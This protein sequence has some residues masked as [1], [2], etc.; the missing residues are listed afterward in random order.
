MRAVQPV[1]YERPA[2][3][4][5]GLGDLVLVMREDVIHAATMD[6]E[7]LAEVFEAHGRTFDMPARAAL[8]QFRL[9][10]HGAIVFVP[11]LPQREIARV[12]R[13]I[14]VRIDAP[15]R[16]RSQLLQVHVAQPAITRKR[17][18]PEVYA[19]LVLV[20]VPLLPQRLDHRDH[21]G[22]MVRGG[23]IDIRPADAQRV[24]V[25]EK[26]PC[27]AVRDGLE[28]L[29]RFAARADQFVLHVRQ[30]HHVP[31]LITPVFQVAAQQILEYVRAEIADVR[32][33]VDRRAARVQAGLARLDRL[34]RLLRAAHR[35]E[36]TQRHRSLLAYGTAVDHNGVGSRILA[37]RRP[38]M[39]NPGHFAGNWHKRPIPGSAQAPTRFVGR[40]FWCPCSLWSGKNVF[41]GIIQIG[42]DVP[43][44]VGKGIRP[45]NVPACPLPA[46]RHAGGMA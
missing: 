8:A 21:L 11:G 18:K 37:F 23:R 1:F 17:R 30:I 36:K 27:I 32:E 28:R 3:A 43:M 34:E 41:Q 42:H 16:T 24:H 25:L 6:V 38:R 45:A 2:R 19:P 31:D 9:P 4:A 7:T 22:H 10:K 39:K 46:R 44:L 5:F 40:L 29:A 15:A 12:R 35:V 20:R 14:F 13:F 33:V 26:R